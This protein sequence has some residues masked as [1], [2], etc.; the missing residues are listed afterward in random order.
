MK[1][2]RAYSLL[3]TLALVVG[4]TKTA[5]KDPVE[6]AATLLGAP[7]AAQAA[8]MASSP[9][10]TL[11]PVYDA[12]L[13]PDPLAEALCT[14]LYT[15]PAVRRAECSGSKNPGYLVTPECT[16]NVTAALAGRAVRIEAAAVEGC[17]VAME[18]ALSSCAW[19]KVPFGSPLPRA[20]DGI[21]TGALGLGASCRSSLECGEGLQCFGVGPMDPGR[22]T[23]P[24]PVGTICGAAVDP[25]V[26]YA[27]QDSAEVTHPACEGYCAHHRCTAF[28]APGEQCGAQIQCGPARDCVE[29]R[30]R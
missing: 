29:G 10:N 3:C 27:R 22:C 9:E 30:C 16:R 20:C 15:R 11:R 18:Q 28:T 17:R 5:A 26:V 1:T 21:V 19:A 23:K 8:P 13:P 4:C 12:K 24:A 25:L 2:N 14:V 7:S 6:S